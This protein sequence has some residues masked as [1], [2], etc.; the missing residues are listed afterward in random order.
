MDFN[1]ENLSMCSL[2]FGLNSPYA[3][4]LVFLPEMHFISAYVW[5]DSMCI[6]FFNKVLSFYFRSEKFNCCKLI[7]IFFEGE[8]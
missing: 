8:K 2:N 1:M 3:Q 7:A 4:L 5:L 6:L